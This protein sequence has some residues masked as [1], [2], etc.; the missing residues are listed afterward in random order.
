MEFMTIYGIYIHP[1]L[2]A[3]ELAL[4]PNYH[5]GTLCIK[6]LTVYTNSSIL[7]VERV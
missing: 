2:P 5:F 1:L 4:L 6:A 7:D 3:T